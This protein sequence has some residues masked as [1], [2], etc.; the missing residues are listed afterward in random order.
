MNGL[1]CL[2][3]H[4]RPSG[5]EITILIDSGSTN[6]YINVNSSIGQSILLPI[7]IKTKTLHGFSVI[8]SRRIINVLDNDLVFFDINELT[9]YDMILGEQGLRQIKAQINLF[10]YKNFYEKQSSLHEINYTNNCSE[11]DNDIANLMYQNEIISENLPFTTTIRAS[12]RTKDEEPVYTKQYPYPYSDK[13]FVDS[14]IQKLLQ[15][16]I[17]EKSFSP[18]NSPIWIV[19]KKGLDSEGK[20]KRR[21]VID[22]QKLNTNTV[23]DKYP[24]PDINLMI[25]NLGRAKIFSTIDLESGFHQILIK[26]QDREKPL[27]R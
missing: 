20:A 7:P 17:I 14:E 12:I 16:G 22:F 27:S 8:K 15:N 21:L 6:N 11:F 1:P 19:A 23:S 25:Q 13:E 5:K 24:I 9:D 4:E 3:R 2:K 26:E 10:E 18:Y